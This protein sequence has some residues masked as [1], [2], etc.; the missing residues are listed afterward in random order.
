VAATLRVWGLDLGLPNLRARPDD[1]EILH[2]TGL[3][4]QGHL[5]LDW[6]VYPSAWVYLCFAWGIAL[7]HAG[8]WLHL[9]PPSGGYA[10]AL[11]TVP[12]RLLLIE[13]GL[14]ALLGTLAVPAL[15][16]LARPVLG[17]EAS[18]L[19][20]WILATNFL[21]VRDSHSLKPDAA[22]SLAV[23]VTLCA[24]VALAHGVTRAR[25]LRAGLALGA[26]TAIK[27][28]GVLL[29]LPIWLGAVLGTRNGGW[30]RL[31][32]PAALLAGLVAAALFLATS[33]YLVL[34]PHARDFLAT[35]AQ[36]VLPGVF[37]A[38][39]ASA[40][41]APALPDWFARTAFGY[42]L[43]FSLRHGAGVAVGLLAPAAVLWALVDRRPLLLLSALFALFYYGVVGSSPF[44]LSRY[45]TPLMPVVALLVGGLVATGV[46]RGSP[47]RGRAVVLVASAL[48]L[49]LQPLAASVAHDRLA[50]RTDTR[51]LATQWL[52]AHLQ[53]GTRVA[54]M[55]TQ[56]W[57]W[58]APQMPPAITSIEVAP[59]ADGLDAARADYLLTHDHVLFSSQVD[60]A[61]LEALAP[62]LRLLAEFDPS[63]GRPG[64]AVFEEADAYYL[65]VAGFG[66]VCRG[67]PSVRI[68]AVEPRPPG[69]P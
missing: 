50:A 37:G 47:R 40:T 61:A 9:L 48:L 58:G 65:P 22:L 6:A 29:A 3:V 14:S 56:F 54:V 53:P 46:E 34:N 52:A 15:M 26:A 60:P 16:A 7:L 49:T 55:G 1:E 12:E 62:R 27:Y 30:R 21:H 25:S 32:P 19:A 28:P 31:L 2:M 41:S 4:A 63:C 44:W 33:P 24:S 59:T 45:L 69:P 8:E 42:H 10:E 13:R 20:G 51:V 11:A 66:A 17:L 5:D 64:A 57:G 67:G 68:Y 39:A 35:I 18:L 38:P 23:V 43:V 36:V